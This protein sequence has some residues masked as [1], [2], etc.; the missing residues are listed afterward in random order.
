MILDE[1]WLF[2]G[3]TGFAARI[4]EW[5]KTLRKKGVAVVFAT[6]SLDDIVR[7]SIAATLRDIGALARTVRGAASTLDGVQRQFANLYPDD[8]SRLDLAALGAERSTTA[9][10]TA[11]DLARTAAQLEQ[12]A[13]SRDGRLRGALAASAAAEGETAAIQSSTQ[14]L[15]VL[16][17]DLASLRTVL[18]A[19]SR[20][21]AEG[22]AR[23][24]AD[25]DAAVE[26]RRR[27][28]GRETAM[29]AAPTFNPLSRARD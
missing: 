10:R 6:Q 17:E 24:A 9:R 21:M 3:E 4:R 26:A 1:A 5:M 18:L 12:L 29:P 16:A 20:L 25:R 2:L 28:W 8:L 11:E 23:Q 27:F 13:R 14:M 7:S 15:S 19:Q 22:A